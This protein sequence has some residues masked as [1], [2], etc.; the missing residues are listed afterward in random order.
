MVELVDTLDSK[1]GFFGSSGSSPL[2]GTIFLII[3]IRKIKKPANSRFFYVFNL[4]ICHYCHT[5]HTL[6]PGDLYSN[7]LSSAHCLVRR[8]LLLKRLAELTG[9]ILGVRWIW[10]GLV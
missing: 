6:V 5:S 3:N 4:T 8:S 7:L 9:R 1:S 2:T 10:R